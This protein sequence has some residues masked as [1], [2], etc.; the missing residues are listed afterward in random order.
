MSG[1]IAMTSNFN[2]SGSILKKNDRG[3][4]VYILGDFSAQTDRPEKRTKI[5]AIDLDDFDEVM[6]KIAPTLNI[7][8]QTTLKFK[9][10]DDFHPDEL[11]K[12][13]PYLAELQQLKKQLS[14]PNT[15]AQAVE[16][17]QGLY[18]TEIQSETESAIAEENTQTENSDDML[19]RLLGKK[20]ESNSQQSSSQ[21]DTASQ[22]ISKIMA[23]YV[24]EEANPQHQVYIN[25]IDST[26]SQYLQTLLHRDDF[27]RVEALWR[28]TEML[29]NEE[30]SDEHTF[31]LV[32][33]NQIDLQSELSVSDGV[34]EEALV[35]H[36]VAGDN[37][38]DIVFLGD[39][40]FSD[41]ETDK[42][43]LKQCSQLAK[44]CNGLFMGSASKSMVDNLIF[45]ETES[46]QEW[47]QYSNELYL[48]NLMLAYPYYL[49]R[50][51]YGKKREPIEAFEFEECTGIPQEKD[52][53]WGAPAFLCARAMIKNKQYKQT[54]DHLYFSDIYS[55]PIEQN[56]EEVLFSVTQE[57]L[58]KTQANKLLSEGIMPLISFRQRQGL[59]LLSLLTLSES[60]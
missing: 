41:S 12:K 32:D 51:P 39:Y 20:P 11:L 40:C 38:Q 18:A 56:G 14:N 58:N 47:A 34:F 54:Q 45:I 8:E 26:T 28:S 33:I 27:Q 19:Q 31:F 23:P 29:V 53:L 59:Q 48:D 22:L 13:T 43:L 24:K 2:V 52:L 50:L 42:E 25:A 30:S 3:Y 5:T 1:R 15:A 10:L 46:T 6:A 44:R 49:L 37:E 7:D 57:V 16:K 9:T 4:R 35:S 17:L 21:Q 36:V 60:V 55:F